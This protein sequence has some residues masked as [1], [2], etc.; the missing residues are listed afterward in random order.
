MNMVKAVCE[1]KNMSEDDLVIAV[2]RER[3]AFIDNWTLWIWFAVVVLTLLTGGFWL[4][5]IVGYHF[6]D[7]FRP[8][9]YCNQCDA[10]ISPKQFRL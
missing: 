6:D 9:Y 4:V 5:F 10:I 2:Q 3:F 1:C 7:I 8:K